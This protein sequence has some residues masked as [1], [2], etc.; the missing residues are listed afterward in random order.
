[1]SII[2]DAL[3]KVQQS[4][5]H[6]PSKP[7]PSKPSDPEHPSSPIEEPQ[8]A[9]MVDRYSNLVQTEPK[10]TI[11]F[12][13]NKEWRDTAILLTCFA[14]CIILLLLIV[15]L[16]RQNPPTPAA[17]PAPAPA[18]SAQEQSVPPPAL[19]KK[20][21]PAGPTDTI[22][23]TGVMKMGAENMALIN[24]EIYEVGEM[25]NGA[26]IVAIEMDRVEIMK[27]SEIK[28]LKVHDR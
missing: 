2:N 6:S 22:I 11:P 3:K 20:T 28:V 18:K 8:G 16:F 4:L 15:F 9:N 5:Q 27:D 1:M 7:E 26:R 25:I 24:N 19:P 12:F 23:V 13:K 17:P 14:I 21:T 10:P